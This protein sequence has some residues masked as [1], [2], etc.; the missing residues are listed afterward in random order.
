M[1]FWITLAVSNPKTFFTKG[2]RRL[3]SLPRTRVRPS[4]LVSDGNFRDLSPL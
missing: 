4:S 1:S 2:D 3:S